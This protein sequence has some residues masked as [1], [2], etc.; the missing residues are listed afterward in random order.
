MRG[1]RPQAAKK[2]ARQE[3]RG[4]GLVGRLSLRELE[5]MRLLAKGASNKQIAIALDISPHIAKAHVTRILHKLE[6]KTR[7]EAAVYWTL[8][9]YEL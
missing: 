6:V 3:K 8:S 9:N 7:T 4:E 1:E 2:G 5:V